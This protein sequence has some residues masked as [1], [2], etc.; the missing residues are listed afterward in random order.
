MEKSGRW[1]KNARRGNPLNVPS[2]FIRSGM[3]I[4]R[5]WTKIPSPCPLPAICS[6]CIVPYSPLC[7]TFARAQGCLYWNAKSREWDTRAL[8]CRKRGRGNLIR[9]K[10]EI[11]EKFHRPLCITVP[12]RVCQVR[13]FFFLSNIAQ[14]AYSQDR[15]ADIPGAGHGC[16]CAD[17]GCL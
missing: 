3:S 2:F 14:S 17:G 10:D 13:M 12:Q 8:D 5:K 15:W 9:N 16:L 11:L 1:G 6:F 7:V 4:R